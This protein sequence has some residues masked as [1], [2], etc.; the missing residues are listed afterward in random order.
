MYSKVCSS[1]FSNVKE[2]QGVSDAGANGVETSDWI[3]SL[4]I[5]ELGECHSQSDNDYKI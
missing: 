2:S 5:E 4:L 3:A 1:I